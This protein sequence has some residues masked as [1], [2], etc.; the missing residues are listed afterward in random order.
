MFQ[1]WSFVTNLQEA[2]GEELLERGLL[3][4]RTFENS[5]TLVRKIIVNTGL[6]SSWSFLEPV[7][8]QVWTAEI[9]GDS[10]SRSNGV[11]P[12]RRTLMFAQFSLSS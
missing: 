6:E 12:S 3:P 9:Y 11:S 2:F 7:V 8:E 1:V 10:N 4:N 5:G